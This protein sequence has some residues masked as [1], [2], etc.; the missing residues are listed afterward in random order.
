MYWK[1][2][3]ATDSSVAKLEAQ[4]LAWAPFAF[5]AARILRDCGILAEA[6][7]GG[8]SGRTLD[9][10]KKC[11][12]GYFSQSDNSQTCDDQKVHYAIYVLADAG[13]STGL[14]A[15][16]DGKYFLTQVGYFILHDKITRVNMDFTHDVCYEGLFYL[17]DSLKSSK[18]SGLHKAFGDWETVY[19]ALAHLP[20]NVRRS[21]FAFDHYFSDS[22]FPKALPIVFAAKPKKLLDIGGNTGKWALKCVGY[23]KDVEVTIADLPGQLDDARK[24]IEAAGFAER[25]KYQNVNL[26]RS[27]VPFSGKF[28]AVWMSQF[29]DC[30]GPTDIMS[31][32]S[33][34]KNA[35]NENGTMYI[36]ETF[37]DLQKYEIS[38]YC[39]DMTSLYFTAIANGKSRMYHSKDMIELVEAA[40]MEVYEVVERVGLFHSIL[41]CRVK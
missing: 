36:M 37:V 33:R 16:N 34:A 22:S 6:E 2:D 9:E 4:K 20:Q 5:Q 30:F 24:N 1:N 11:C 17:D 23:D 18:P 27:D 41:K 40:G 21:W 13:V 8:D 19:A 14:L 29:L 12:G 35:L 31:I 10:L 38:K 39:L 3:E 28:D 32:V 25:V 15:E 26:L 7:K